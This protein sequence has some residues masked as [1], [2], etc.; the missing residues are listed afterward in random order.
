MDVLYRGLGV[1][2]GLGNEDEV[3]CLTIDS[4]LVAVDLGESQDVSHGQWTIRSS[5][6]IMLAK[7]FLILRQVTGPET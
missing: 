1:G 7:I 2:V 3:D 5:C 6:K 4:Q